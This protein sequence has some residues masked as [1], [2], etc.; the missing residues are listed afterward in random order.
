MK[1]LAD[2]IEALYVAFSD[3]PK[4]V[5]IHACPCCISDE[6]IRV[7]LSKPLRDLSGGELACYSSTVFL[8]AGSEADYFYFLPR[9]VEVAA[10]ED[11][12]YSDVEIIGRAIGETKPAGWPTERRQALLDVLHAAIQ[13]VLEEEVWTADGWICAIAKMGIEVM[14]FLEQIETSPSQLLEY[15]EYNSKA[16]IKD[17]LGNAFWDRKDPGFD[18]VFGWFKSPRTSR[19][20]QEAYGLAPDCSQEASDQP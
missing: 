1:S 15:Y 19:I 13:R 18:V 6:G 7:L 8:T 14:P 2:C 16:L 3:V 5:E 11:G 17:H 20:I 10:T 9:I 12:W 4:P